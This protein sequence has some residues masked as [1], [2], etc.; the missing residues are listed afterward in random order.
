MDSAGKQAALF[1]EQAIEEDDR[2]L[3]SSGEIEVGRVNGQ[4]NR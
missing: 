3:D 2:G 1:V 4:R